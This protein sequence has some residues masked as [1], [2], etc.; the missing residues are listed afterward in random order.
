[1][2]DAGMTAPPHSGTDSPSRRAWVMLAVSLALFGAASAVDSWAF[3]HFRLSGVYDRD[4]GRALRSMGYWPLWI[5][6]SF[7]LWLTDRARGRGVQRAAILAGAVTVAGVSDEV[8]KLVVRRDRPGVLDG[9][10]AFRSWP[11]RP[12]DSSGFGMPSSHA[13][14]AFAAAAALTE[15][16]P[17]AA[18][19]WY[20]LAVG[21]AV[22]RVLSGAHFVSDVVVG[23]LLG[24]MIAT[25]VAQRVAHATAA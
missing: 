10:Y 5:A 8:L 24:I 22:T 23:A 12:F 3:H 4:W 13:I 6:L 2:Y 7:A 15:F 14:I 25:W 20:G 1:V 9:A 19:V 11:D 18:I 17:A 16:F 21:C